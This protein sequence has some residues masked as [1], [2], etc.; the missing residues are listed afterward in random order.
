MS[1]PSG[2]Q[3]RTDLHRITANAADIKRVTARFMYAVVKADGYGCGAQAVARAVADSA[4]G[5]YVFDLGESVKAELHTLGKPVI[6]VDHP[7]RGYTPDD[8]LSAHVRPI[9]HCIERARELRNCRPVLS[10]DTGMHRFAASPADVRRLLAEGVIDEAMTHA[11]RVDEARR[12]VELCGGRGLRL[13]AA[14]TALLGEPDALLDATRPGLALYRGAVRVTARVIE[15]RDLPAGEPAGYA[16]FVPGQDAPARLG[17]ILGG[18]SN[19][20]KPGIC[21]IRGARR[22]I[23][24]TGMQSAFV[25]LR[26]GEDV[27]EEVVLLGDTLTEA[28]VAAVWKTSEQE[29]LVRLGTSG[30]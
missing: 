4:D 28:D 5:Y 15:A 18:Y 26:P 3:R 8:Y 14:A 20:V 6:A 19:G 17:V 11:V 25:E 23:W 2:L 1:V 24:E 9:V 12:L 10:V 30:R 13:H 21:L 22:R 27:G 7:W 29:V 16:R